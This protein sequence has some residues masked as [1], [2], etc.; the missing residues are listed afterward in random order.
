MKQ[1][2]LRWISKIVLIQQMVISS[3]LSHLLTL[4]TFNRTPKKNK[5]IYFDGLL[6]EIEQINDKIA[7]QLSL[8]VDFTENPIILEANTAT[9]HSIA[10]LS[11]R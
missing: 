2:T 10:R 11:D 9:L 7:R 1:I 6:Y 5:I 8:E 3:L 4:I